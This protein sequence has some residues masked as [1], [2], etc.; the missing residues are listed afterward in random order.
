M[1]AFSLCYSNAVVLFEFTVQWLDALGFPSIHAFG[2]P[3]VSMSQELLGMLQCFR[4]AGALGAQIMLG[5]PILDIGFLHDAIHK[6]A[7]H[8]IPPSGPAGLLV[9]VPIPQTLAK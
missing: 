2:R 5:E 8:R 9:Q 6:I 4:I 3:A 1:R 7:P